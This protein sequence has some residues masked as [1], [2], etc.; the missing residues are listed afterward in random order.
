MSDTSVMGQQTSSTGYS[1]VSLVDLK[2]GWEL[3]IVGGEFIMN[4]WK[5]AKY[6]LTA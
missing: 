1:H 4:A 2:F 3:E 6:Q 5:P